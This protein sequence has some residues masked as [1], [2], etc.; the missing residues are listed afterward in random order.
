MR[1]IGRN[2][3]EEWLVGVNL[4]LGPAKGGLE[5]YVRAKTFGL[6]D[7]VIFQ[8]HAVEV[9]IGSV[10]WEVGAASLEC[11]SD[12]ACPMDEHVAETTVVRLV[13]GFVA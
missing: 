2:V 5:E 1:S 13:G 8:K 9:F 3:R 6:H 10:W 4:L 11:L 7:R 12:S